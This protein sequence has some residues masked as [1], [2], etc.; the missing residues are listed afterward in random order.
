MSNEALPVEAAAGTATKPSERRLSGSLGPVSIAFM[1]VAA[2]APLTVVSA[3]SINALVSNGP[4]IA[5]AYLVGSA[6]MLLFVVGYMAMTPHV[7]RPGAFYAYVTAGI[8]RATGIGVSFIALLTY[9]SLAIGVYVFFGFIAS[10]EVDR[11]TSGALSLSW[12]QWSAIAM[13]V[14]GV[15]GYLNIE[16]SAKVLFVALCLE[17]LL[18]VVVSIAI[19]IKGGG[20]EGI[21]A[22]SWL[23]SD[24]INHAGGLGMGVLFGVSI[25]GGIEATAI[26]RDEARTPERTIPRATYGAVIGV[27]I[28]YVF[29]IWSFLQAYGVGGFADAVAGNPGDLYLATAMQFVG[30]VIA[31][32]V[33]V[34]LLTSMFASVLSYHN[35]LARYLHALGTRRVLPGHLGSVHGTQLSPHIASVTVTVGSLVLIGLWAASGLDPVAQVFPWHIAVATIALIV[36]F[37]VTSASVVGFFARNPLDKRLWNTK[38]APVV[39]I[40]LL[41]GVLVMAYKNFALLT[42]EIP[43]WGSF[44]LAVMPF[45][46]LGVGLVIALW[47]RTSRPEVYADL[48]DLGEDELHSTVVHD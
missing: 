44:L 36:M 25:F 39:S 22:T 17:V 42:G 27:A 20:P 26:F 43:A 33:S 2:A 46:A 40:V 9:L 24:V 14:A 5:F 12:W 7:R 21:S 48:S 30:S 38:I 31:N 32:V 47:L 15:L 18:V 1:V 8:N 11:W 19:L 35:I 16:F 4:G 45:L 10:L 28:F 13:V 23:R 3:T 29:A 41:A 37:I 34:M 6:L